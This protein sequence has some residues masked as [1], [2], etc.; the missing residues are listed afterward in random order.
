MLEK[1]LDENWKKHLE[2]EF[3]KNYMKNL[4]K[5]LANDCK[6]LDK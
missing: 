3:K 5:F 2:K 1:Y 6:E 4:N